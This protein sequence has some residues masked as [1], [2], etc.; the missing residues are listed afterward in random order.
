MFLYVKIKNS[1]NTLHLLNKKLNEHKI[2]AT[3]ILQQVFDKFLNF[4]LNKYS[5]FFNK[6]RKR[7]SKKLTT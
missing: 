5:K 3:N 1:L 2:E 7:T 6:I 4:E